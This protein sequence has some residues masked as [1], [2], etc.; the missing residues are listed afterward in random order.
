VARRTRP[1][2][3]VGA[4]EGGSHDGGDHPLRALPLTLAAGAAATAFGLVPTLLSFTLVGAGGLLLAARAT[5][6][7]GT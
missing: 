5:T 3:G 1:G 2:A 4:R 7:A 6:A